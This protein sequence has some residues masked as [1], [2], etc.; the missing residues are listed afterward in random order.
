MKRAKTA[1]L[2]F[3]IAKLVLE[4]IF[5][6][7]ENLLSVALACI[8]KRV[9]SPSTLITPT[10]AAYVDPQRPARIFTHES[11]LMILRL[12]NAL[13]RPIAVI[14]LAGFVALSGAD[15]HAGNCG[16][17][18]SRDRLL[19]SGPFGEI[20][21]ASGRTVT[22][23]DIRVAGI[24]HGTGAFVSAHAGAPV[25]LQLGDFRPDRWGRLHAGIVLSP[26]SSRLDLAHALVARGIAVVDSGAETLCDNS[27][28]LRE[29]QARRARRGIWR[30]PETLPVSAENRDALR[31]RMGG[32]TIVEGV[33]RSVGE[34]SRRTYIDFGRSWDSA[35]TVIVPARLW[36][37][38]QAAGMEA[39]TLKGRR[40]RV[41]GIMQEWRG[42][43]IELTTVD[44][45]EKLE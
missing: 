12:T 43:A 38:V 33:V 21:L 23:A 10:A 7:V 41:R 24:D 26:D 32:F 3:F 31:A 4:H 5:W 2:S 40:I 30:D 42:P 44:F 11:A 45:I 28:L 36:S 17:T 19:E 22:L 29:E 6:K 1:K 27:L 39:D 18:I 34:R 20:R 9:H 25:E 16:G 37:K 13:L 35:F 15:A 8:R 14:G